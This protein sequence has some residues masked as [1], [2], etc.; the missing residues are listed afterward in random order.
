MN[1]TSEPKTN[2]RRISR[3]AAR[4]YWLA[5]PEERRS[6]KAVAERFH[7]SDVRI[8]QIARADDWP[9]ALAELQT[10]ADRIERQ[11]L[12][13]ELR[14]LARNRAER[15]GRTLEAYDRLNDLLLE[16]IPIGED[17]LVDVDQVREL[18]LETLITGLPGLFKMA[19][20]AAG[21]ATDKVAIADVHPVL[22]SFARIAVLRAPA[23]E[24]GEVMRELESAAA[25]LIALEVDTG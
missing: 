14:R 5:L 17:G 19:E 8:G 7:V 24:R 25:G 23:E 16:R 2:G 1:T 11:E 21:E 22:I 20:L 4:A 10:Q 9:K 6:Y 18:K 15:L 13:K 3:T 12:A